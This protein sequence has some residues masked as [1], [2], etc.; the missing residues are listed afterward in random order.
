MRVR[1]AIAAITNRVF[2]IVQAN[3]AT[4]ARRINMGIFFFANRKLP[5]IHS[6]SVPRSRGQ[7]PSHLDTHKNVGR[8]KMVISSILSISNIVFSKIFKG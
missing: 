7:K 6:E 3:M 8:E 2:V 5:S 4:G 1:L